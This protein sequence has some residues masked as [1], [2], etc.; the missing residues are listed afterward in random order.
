MT[1]RGREVLLRGNAF[2]G[3]EKLVHFYSEEFTIYQFFF[4]DMC[5]T[6]NRNRLRE[7]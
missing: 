7:A 1:P 6:K 2:S 5:Y 4:T 3:K